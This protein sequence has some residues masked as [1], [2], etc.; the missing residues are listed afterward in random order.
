MDTTNLKSWII[1]SS[2]VG[3]FV[4]LY[5]IYGADAW[6][7]FVSTSGHGG[8]F[9]VGIGYAGIAFLSFIFSWWLTKSLKP[10]KERE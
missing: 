7:N 10:K 5:S 8:V 3:F 2:I 6:E 9:E 1:K 4:A